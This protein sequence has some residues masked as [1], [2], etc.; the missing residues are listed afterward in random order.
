V[1]AVNGENWETYVEIRVFK[2]DLPAK[3]DINK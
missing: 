3:E 1:V 2:V